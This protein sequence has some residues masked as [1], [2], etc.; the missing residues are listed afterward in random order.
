MSIVDDFDVPDGT[1]AVVQR[2]SL[3]G[4]YYVDLVLPDEFDPQAGPFLASGDVIDD[5]TTQP[6]VEQLAEQA[7][8]VV[9]ALTADDIGATVARSEEHTSELQSLM[10]ISNAVF[11]L[12]KKKT[13]K[14]KKPNNSQK[15]KRKHINTINN[16]IE[17][18][19]QLNTPTNNIN[20][21]TK[22]YTN[23]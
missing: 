7:A 22:N 12:K 10:R 11:C 6:D 8:A 2:T 5:A 19:N 14:N 3:L 9:G 16:N 17:S 1:A 13:S 20:Y 4:E 23:I 18:T 21:D 15:K